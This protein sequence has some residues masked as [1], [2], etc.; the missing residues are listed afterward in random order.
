MN[1][2]I[3]VI[4]VE[5]YRYYTKTLFSSLKQYESEEKTFFIIVLIFFHLILMFPVY[6]KTT[7]ERKGDMN[8]LL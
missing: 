3:Q 7:K 5:M 1:I 8:E 2:K 4:I 6:A